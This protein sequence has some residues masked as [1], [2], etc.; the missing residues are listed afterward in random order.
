MST[1]ACQK[2]NKKKKLTD[3]NEFNEKINKQETGI[4]RELFK[5][6]FNFQRPSDML[7]SLCKANTSQNNE[8]ISLT[9]SGLKDLKKE[10]KEMSAERDKN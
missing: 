3:V 5:K 4:S 7:K 8:L 6:H 10:I 1:S 2:K 9:N